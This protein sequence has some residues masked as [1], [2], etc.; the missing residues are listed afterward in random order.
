MFFTLQFYDKED[1]DIDRLIADY[2]KSI[3]RLCYL[4]LKDASLA[5]DAAWETLYKAYKGYSKFRK[6]SSEKTWISKIAINV[7][8]NYMRKSSYKEITCDD[9]V[10][11]TYASDNEVAEEFTNDES[12]ALLS[13]VYELPVKYKQVIL[14]RYY[15]ELSVSD[16]AGV[17]NE[18]ENT[19]SVRIKRGKE[20]LK[21]KL[22][23]GFDDE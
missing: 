2:S 22:K 16:I 1:P 9:F 5:E 23:E 12:I 3:T 15:Q 8:K 4:I 10:S 21:E 19:I 6:E 14:L 17:L 18:K 7:C 11:L 20:M 13:A